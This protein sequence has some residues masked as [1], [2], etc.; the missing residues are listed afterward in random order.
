VVPAV[1]K[2]ERET[3][4]F[5]EVEASAKR[6]PETYQEAVVVPASECTLIVCMGC[7]DRG[8]KQEQ[9]GQILVCRACGR[10][11]TR[12]EVLDHFGG[13]PS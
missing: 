12:A 1:K 9:D 5:A 4:F 3:A 13:K 10:R 11:H 7:G 2:R 8:L 6:G